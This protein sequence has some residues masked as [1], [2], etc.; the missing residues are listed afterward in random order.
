VPAGDV[1]VNVTSAAAT[2]GKAPQLPKGGSVTIGPE[3]L[4]LSSGIVQSYLVIAGFPVDAW[5]LKMHF[6]S[7]TPPPGT[8]R[9]CPALAKAWFGRKK[10]SARGG[11]PPLGG[12]PPIANVTSFDGPLVPQE[13]SDRTRT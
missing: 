6:N 11:V 12:A 4:M 13:L 8:T 1:T 7:L 10:K 5:P 9:H 3:K 2:P